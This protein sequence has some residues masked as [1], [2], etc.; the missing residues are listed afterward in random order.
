MSNISGTPQSNN[1][2]KHNQQVEKLIKENK[3]LNKINKSLKEDKKKLEKRINDLETKLNDIL[4]G[5][6]LNTSRFG[7]SQNSGKSQ[8]K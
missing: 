7:G 8:S 1:S 6:K 5:S 2:A 4:K 3:Q